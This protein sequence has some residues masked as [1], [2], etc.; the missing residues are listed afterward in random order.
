MQEHCNEKVML[1]LRKRSKVAMQSAPDP[2]S[3][4]R[5]VLDY[6]V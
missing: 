1:F 5:E 2:F 3:K 6:V 4:Q